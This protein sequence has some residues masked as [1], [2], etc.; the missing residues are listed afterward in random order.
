MA[1]FHFPPMIDSVSSLFTAE[2]PT[3]TIFKMFS[4]FFLQSET[5]LLRAGKF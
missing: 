3:M 5:L 2:F 1:D 4:Q